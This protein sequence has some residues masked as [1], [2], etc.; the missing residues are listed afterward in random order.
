MMNNT[1]QRRSR[2]SERMSWNLT[3]VHLAIFGYPGS[4]SQ[5]EAIGTWDGT[6]YFNRAKVDEKFTVVT[7]DRQ[8]V[9]WSK[10]VAFTSSPSISRTLFTLEGG[11]SVPVKHSLTLHPPSPSPWQPPFFCLYELDRHRDQWNP[12][13]FV[14]SRLAYFTSFLCRNSLPF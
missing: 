2:W 5:T 13:V 8:T 9:P 11:N 1:S 10:Y 7:I 12:P 4:I 3:C 14:L 6:V